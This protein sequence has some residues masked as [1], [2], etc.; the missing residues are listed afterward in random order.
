MT[1]GDPV[2]AGDPG[3]ATP[4]GAATRPGRLSGAQE[5]RLGDELLVYIPRT[6]TAH[7]LNRS[8]VAIWELC[9]G[10][11]TTE[12]ISQE[13]GQ[14][15]GQP[16]EAMLSDVRRGVAQLGELGLLEAR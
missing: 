12:E 4:D 14:W 3:S 5:Y 1:A 2:L 10:T 6:A 16:G 13:L 15:L 9:D 7:A 8:A 11:R